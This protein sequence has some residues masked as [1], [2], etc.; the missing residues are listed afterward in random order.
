MSCHHSHC[1]R[2]WEVNSSSRPKLGHMGYGRQAVDCPLTRGP[3][4]YLKERYLGK[5]I[6]LSGVGGRDPRS[7]RT[8]LLNS[9]NIKN[10]KK[11]KK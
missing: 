1:T 8:D 11:I 4:Q 5:C 6:L 3:A 10:I 2:F 9:G 7:D